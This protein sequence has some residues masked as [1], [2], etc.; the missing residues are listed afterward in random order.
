MGTI[1]PEAM[2]ALLAAHE[3]PCL[4]IYQP[5]QRSYPDN[6][7]GPIRYRNLLRKAEEQLKKQG[8]NG[9]MKAVLEKV[10]RLADDP[11][12][13]TRRQDGLAV[14]AS[15]NLFHTVDL[16]R[17]VDE[18]VVVA[19]TFHV[20]PLLRRLQTADRYQVLCLTRNRVRMLE[21]NRDAL[22]EIDLKG[23]PATLEEALGAETRERRMEQA[24]G[25]NS[26][27]ERR[28]GGPN[29]PA[30]TVGQPAHGEPAKLEAERFFRVID[31]AVWE[32]HSRPS[33]LPLILAALPENQPLFRGLSHNQHLLPDGIFGNPDTMALDD[34]GHAAW[35]LVEPHHHNYV[36]Q[37]IDVYQASRVRGLATDQ[38]GEGFRQARIGRVGTVLIDADLRLPGSIDPQTG[39]PRYREDADDLLDELG[40]L[41]L[42]MKGTVLVLPGEVMPTRTGLAAIYRY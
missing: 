22:D 10:A 36:R 40:E 35:K 32:N 15:P 12:F 23:V 6:Q 25:G 7:Q 39:E 19:E 11:H 33:G 1:T 24:P 37:V 21:G 8:G 38:L 42:R 5:T 17:K 26:T 30:L 29:Q 18:E 4:S 16:Q 20:K 13:W 34:L 2:T 41:V 3:G 14:F 28:A 27:G 9:Q 31:R